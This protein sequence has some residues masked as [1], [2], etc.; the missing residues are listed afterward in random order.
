MKWNAT[1]G[2]K[3]LISSSAMLAPVLIMGLTSLTVSSGLSKELDNAVNSIARKQ[4]LAGQISTAAADMNALERGIAFSTVLQQPDKAESFKQQFR[5]AESRV[6]QYLD[7]FKSLMKETDSKTEL[8][9]LK[10]EYASIKTAHEGLLQM[11]AS[12]QMDQALKSFDE[13]LLPKLNQMSAS[14]KKP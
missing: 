8:E 12:Q 5:S 2:A 13:V 7:T 14:A 11:L 3:L 6:E 9:D 1:I 10:N 4:L